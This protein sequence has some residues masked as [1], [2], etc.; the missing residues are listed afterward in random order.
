MIMMEE[1]MCMYFQVTKKLN[2]NMII[3]VKRLLKNGSLMDI[4]SLTMIA[5][6]PSVYAKKGTI[7]AIDL[8]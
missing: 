1:L 2:L 5:H 8:Q 7:L 3:I 4:G 6:T